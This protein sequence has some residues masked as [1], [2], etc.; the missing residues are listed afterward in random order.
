MLVQYEATTHKSAPAVLVGEASTSKAKSKRAG[1][2][3]R[4]KGKEKAVAA[5]ASAECAPAAP[6]EKG[7]RKL[8]VLSG[9]WQM[10][11]TYIAKK[12]GIERG[13]VHNSSSTQTM[14]VMRL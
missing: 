10:M 6:K 5:T 12:M 8:E 4:K 14:M 7:K 9:R 3:K 13:S 2:W 11:S 1:C